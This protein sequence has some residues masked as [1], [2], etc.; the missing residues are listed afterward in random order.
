MSKRSNDGAQAPKPV[1]KAKVIT[2]DPPSS[3]GEVPGIGALY[4]STVVDNVSTLSIPICT[5]VAEL[6]KD[7]EF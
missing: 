6:L 3:V 2:S 1:K 4:A 5:I 7:G